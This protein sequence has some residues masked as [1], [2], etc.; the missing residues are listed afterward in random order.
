LKTDEFSEY[1][2]KWQWASTD[3]VCLSQS[4]IKLY[5][6]NINTALAF[7]IVVMFMLYAE[8]GEAQ[9]L[10]DFGKKRMMK[11]WDMLS[12]KIKKYQNFTH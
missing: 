4:L 8:L 5:D 2:E 7:S 12:L 9:E 10:G 6:T 3:L 1:V 11:K